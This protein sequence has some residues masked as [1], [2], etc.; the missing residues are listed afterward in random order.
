MNLDYDFL[1][2]HVNN[3]VKNAKTFLQRNT[4]TQENDPRKMK[5]SMERKK[6]KASERQRELH[7]KKVRENEEKKK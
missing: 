4:N 1:D 6:R 7:A 2:K 3:L 5:E